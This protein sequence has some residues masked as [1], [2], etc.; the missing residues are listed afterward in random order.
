MNC[1]VITR[2]VELNCFTEDD[3]RVWKECKKY[4][5]KL[6]NTYNTV[7]LKKRW[8]VEVRLHLLSSVISLLLSQLIN[9]FGLENG[10]NW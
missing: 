4:A 7:Q 6:I 10:E 1:V 2:T 8:T 9:S 3:E 5:V